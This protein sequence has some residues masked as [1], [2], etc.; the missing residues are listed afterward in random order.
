M[1]RLPDRWDN[2]GARMA[3]FSTATVTKHEP[4]VYPFGSMP[5]HSPTGS[6]VVIDSD[7]GQSGA[8]AAEG[9]F[10][11]WSRKLTSDVPPR[12]LPATLSC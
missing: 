5:S 10:S 11:V 7:V 4:A 8:S 9:D 2:L 6:D 1:E 12:A 3:P